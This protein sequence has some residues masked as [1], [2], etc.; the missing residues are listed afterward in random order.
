MSFTWLIYA[1]TLHEVIPGKFQL[2]GYAD[3]HIFKCAFNA[4]DRKA[5]SETVTSIEFCAQDIKTWMDDNRL[6]MNTSK[7]EFILF[8]NSAQ[9][10]KCQTK[11]LKTSIKNRCSSQ[12][13]LNI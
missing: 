13:Q 12:I 10:A 7:R 9:V 11:E 2:H 8:G 5:E 3:D 1:S 6:R 4:S